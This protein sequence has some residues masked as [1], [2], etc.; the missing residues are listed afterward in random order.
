MLSLS[1]PA[2]WILS[3]EHAVI[4]GFPAIVFPLH[5]FQ[6]TL[7]FEPNANELTCDCQTH[8]GLDSFV[9]GLIHKV[10]QKL[11]IQIYGAITIINTIPIGQ[12]LGFSA[13]LAVNIAR[14]LQKLGHI[15]QPEILKTATFIENIIHLTSS[16]ID[17]HGVYSNQVLHYQNGQGKPINHYNLPN[18]WLH[19]TE[20]VGIT[21][22]CI[23]NVS[24]LHKNFP[25]KAA[26]I[27]QKMGSTTEQLL[28]VIQNPHHHDWVRSI[29]QAQECF[30]D[31]GLITDCLDQAMN[32]LSQQGCLALKPT[33]SGKGGFLIGLWPD[34]HHPKNAIP[35]QIKR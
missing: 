20:Q 15:K 16:G 17:V 18:L 31:W 9:L 7:L 25:E 11:N 29:Q 23:K 27:D 3:G 19:P 22:S 26:L 8:D 2:K 30:R 21:S 4:R 32:S 6:C 5:H 13:S 14:L 12:G 1:T 33:G 24:Q 28:E 34:H 10:I 35:L